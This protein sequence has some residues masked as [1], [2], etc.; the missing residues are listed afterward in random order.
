MKVF[1][2]IAVIASLVVQ[3]CLLSGC[4]STTVEFDYFV[5]PLMT[6]IDSNKDLINKMYE[7]GV[8]QESTCKAITAQLD[9][10]KEQLNTTRD[11]LQKLQS[12][13]AN[14]VASQLN[15]DQNL[16]ALLGS[17]QAFWCPDIQEAQ[18]YNIDEDQFAGKV[19]PLLLE[20]NEKYLYTTENGVKRQLYSRL[21][22]ATE[23]QASKAAAFEILDSSAKEQ[24]RLDEKGKVYVLNMDNLLKITDG[25]QIDQVN[26]YMKSYISAIEDLNASNTT[27]IVLPDGTKITEENFK[28]SLN[29]VFE[30]LKDQQGSEI[31]WL[32]LEQFDIIQDQVLQTDGM[33]GKYTGTG[34]LNQSPSGWSDTCG[35]DVKV[36]NNI[37]GVDVTIAYMRVEEL[38]ELQ[39][40]DLINAAKSSQSS[41]MMVY[42][43]NFYLFAYPIAVVDAVNYIDNNNYTIQYKV[44]NRVLVQFKDQ[45]ILKVNGDIDSQTTTESAYVNIGDGTIADYSSF[46]LSSGDITGEINLTGSGDRGSKPSGQHDSDSVDNIPVFILRDYLEAQFTPGV[47]N[48]GAVDEQL[49]CYGRLIRLNLSSKNN[50]SYN[51]DTPIGYYI[52]QEHKKINE[53]GFQDLYIQNFQGAEQ[54]NNSTQTGNKV[55]RLPQR[56]EQMDFETQ[57]DL[58]QTQVQLLPTKTVSQIKPVLS[59]PGDLDAWD[60]DMQDKPQMYAIVTNLD[61]NTSGLLQHWIQQDNEKLSL[62]WWQSWLNGHRYSY[63][64]TSES[65]NT[66]LNAEYNIQLSDRNY[67]IYDLEKTEKQN[68]IFKQLDESKLMTSF[69]TMTIILGVIGEVYGAVLILC[70]T[71][72]T[73]I[74]LGVGLLEKAQLGHM[75]AIRYKD[76]GDYYQKSGPIPVTFSELIVK[77]LIIAA[78]GTILLVFNIQDIIKILINLFSGVSWAVERIIKGLM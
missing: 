68:E 3:I 38:N 39:V 7:A 78:V 8:M 26:K 20:Q 62:A 61:L 77:I 37:G 35:H 72:D 54:L 73:S 32:D 58:Q 64:L 52:D 59:F 23:S 15:N 6:R 18:N 74:G 48:D 51:L 49:V 24:I 47:I 71:F 70:W 56:L 40:N 29:K 17:V 27:N 13:G 14:G 2:K 11:N 55:L 75:T 28:S 66:W 10:K 19:F 22:G 69:R 76:E 63:K 43:G 33:S 53:T 57:G 44:D 1:K 9:S 30:P 34:G 4:N 67:V 36:V 31:C 65:V 46:I 12:Q 5:Q 16:R 42:D 45:T 21:P 60:K 41:R 50:A 25:G